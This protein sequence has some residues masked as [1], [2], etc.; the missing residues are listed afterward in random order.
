VI[1]M[2]QVLVRNIDKRTLD[3]LKARAALHKNSLQA[4]LK[5]VLDEASRP[6]AANALAVA[7]RIRANLRRKGI[8]FSD[9]GRIQAEGRR[10]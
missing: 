1:A 5:G 4:E 3:A 6:L 10:R 2:P 7:R 8:V 9:S